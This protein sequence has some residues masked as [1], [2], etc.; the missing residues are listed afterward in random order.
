[1]AQRLKV[2]MLLAESK[3]QVP[4]LTESLTIPRDC[5][6][7]VARCP[8]LPPWVLHKRDTHTQIKQIKKFKGK[9]RQSGTPR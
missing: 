8:F 3:V 1:M 2:L 9:W 6:F 7:R 4:E 5:S